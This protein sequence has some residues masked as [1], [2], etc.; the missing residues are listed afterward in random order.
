MN[1]CKLLTSVLFLLTT[2]SGFTQKIVYSEVDNDDSRRMTFE[3]IGKV[4][5]NFLVYKNNRNKNF[6]S[7]Y[8]NE[9][10]QIGKEEQEY[11]TDRVI[12]IDFIPYPD[13]AYLVYQYQKKNVIYCEAV[14]VDG[15][16]K[17]I[18]DIISLDTTHIGFAANNKVYS[19]I[20]SED[21][22]KIIIF[23]INSRNKSNYI[24][25]SLLFDQK[26]DL[27]NRS[28][29]DMPMEEYHDYLDE[30]NVDNDGD[31]VFTKFNR[32]T[33]ETINNTALIWKPAMADTFSSIN[34]QDEKVFFDEPHIKVDNYNKRYFITSF[35]YTKRRGNI[36]GFYFYAWDKQTKQPTLNNSLVLGEELR[37]EAK[38]D[39]ANIKTAFNDYFIRN[40]IIKKDGGFVINTESYYTTSRYNS[41]NRLN[42]LYGMPLSMYD[43]YSPYSPYYNSWYWR[44][45]D[46]NQN[47]RFHAN[48]ITILSFDK[49]GALQWNSVVHK[50]QYDDQSEERISYQT[51]NT[52]GQLHYLF[53]IDEKAALLL[54]DFTLSPDGE[55]NHNPTLKNLDRGYEFMPKYG[56]QV[57]SYQMI[58]PC[59]YRN[60]ICFAKIEFNQ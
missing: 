49:N 30:F 48:N 15:N 32:N 57:S 42:Y 41:W 6:I 13:F 46:N 24:V 2:I 34:V 31:F 59:Y 58:L 56:K 18:S 3:I 22:S 51:M 52:G 37:S 35:Y 7:V 14:K 19:T 12:N 53:N 33:N 20:N 8:N 54:N 28:R 27:L 40:I 11:L 10:E 60:N 21:K 45:R 17:K 50:D 47:V 43:Y 38:G 26:L 25:T 16:G 39:D 29:F 1:F 36:E 5:G 55:L 23:K 44:Y 9:M 4:S